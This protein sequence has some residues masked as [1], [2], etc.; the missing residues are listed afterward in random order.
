M[1][2]QVIKDYQTV[3]TPKTSDV[4]TRYYLCDACFLVGLESEDRELLAK[5]EMALASPCFP[6]YLGRRSCPPVMPLCLGIREFSLAEALRREP[7]HASEWYRRRNIG[8]RLRLILETP[9]GRNAWYS[10]RDAPVSF[11]ME[12][13]RYGM[14][15]IEREQYV[16]MG[17]DEHDPMAEL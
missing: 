6:L 14:R 10:L 17:N 11:N 7:W 15:G 5:L 3:K 2:G 4:T 12:H 8:A 1:P 13:R 9:K 16:L